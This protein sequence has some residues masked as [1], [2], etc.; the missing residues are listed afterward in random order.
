M[1]TPYF[2]LEERNII[3]FY[4]ESYTAAI[5]ILNLE[6]AKLKREIYKE[7]GFIRGWFTIRKIE[8]IK[9]ND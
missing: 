7:S 9:L 8:N 5:F 1:K 2:N 6:F 4:P 3:R